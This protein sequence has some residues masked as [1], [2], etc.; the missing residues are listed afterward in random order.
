MNNITR[1]IV[2]ENPRLWFGF[3]DT[4][5]LQSPLFPMKS[6]LANK[7]DIIKK[8]IQVIQELNEEIESQDEELSIV[9]EDWKALKLECDSQTKELARAKDELNYTTNELAHNINSSRS[10]DQIISLLSDKINLMSTI[11]NELQ[12]E[13]KELRNKDTYN[14]YYVFCTTSGTITSN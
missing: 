12:E 13:I 5:Q 9:I 8:Q 6:E 1:L 10:K 14:P 4:K 2:R 7:E 11:N 3:S